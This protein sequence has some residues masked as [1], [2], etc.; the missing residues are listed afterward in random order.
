[1]NNKE[2]VTL[3]KFRKL[4][5]VNDI[6]H[7]KR[8]IENIDDKTMLKLKLR[9]WDKINTIE[10]DESVEKTDDSS[11]L[12]N[13]DKITSF[14]DKLN[15]KE[16][17]ELNKIVDEGLCAKC[18][19][20]SIVCPTEDI[21]FSDFP[22]INNKCD[23][24]GHG[25]CLEVCPRINSGSSTIRSIINSKEEFYNTSQFSSDI[26]E[27]GDYI[28][29]NLMDNN[30]IDGAI[31]VGNYKWKPI[32]MIVTDSESITDISK[33]QYAISTLDAI[34]E[35]GE[36]GLK[37]IAI[38]GLPC[39]IA[40]LRNIQYFKQ[41]TGHEVEASSDGKIAKI[42]KIEYL[43]GIFCKS[44][45]EHDDMLEIL[46]EKSI[47]INNVTK[48][49]IKENK[50]LVYEENLI[51]SISYDEINPSS[52]CLMCND[53]DA[54]LADISIGNCES[55]DNISIV[56]RTGKG[57]EILE[58]L[59]VQEGLDFEV[60][61]RQKENKNT[62]FT[63]EINRRSRE[64]EYNSYY[65][66]WKYPGCTEGRN[67]LVNIL[68][69]TPLAGIY[70]LDTIIELTDIAKKYDV[71]LNISNRKNFHLENIHPK[72]IDDIYSE[73]YKVTDL[74]NSPPSSNLIACVG[75]HSCKMSLINTRDLELE[76]H[77]L[78]TSKGISSKFKVGIGGCAYKCIHY[79][80]L[81]F[82]IHPVKY[83]KIND[84]CLGCGRCPEICTQQGVYIEDNKAVINEENCIGC[85]KCFNFCPNDAKDIK[86]EGY[87]LYIGG[88]A[89]RKLAEASTIEVYNE[90][91][92]LKILENVLDLT[93][94]YAS[95]PTEKVAS[96]MERI[97]K[98]EF[99]KQVKTL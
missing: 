22:Y 83:P 26:T 24:K 78:L 6:I 30:K 15:E 11:P 13:F 97:G 63:E 59:D 8:K 33:E 96:I 77:K 74:F 90:D 76:C 29:K 34:T 54:E 43:I 94:E 88:R 98:D 38:I 32:S 71:N 21:I 10:S 57:R 27:A 84:E 49:E 89:V 40:G 52:G 25:M 18:G 60:F 28:L 58:Y 55:D 3:A 50:V 51:H 19:S 9:V 69:P 81:D 37:K 5:D 66:I 41:N 73:L 95:Y 1:M 80:V 65:Y 44:K 45:Y 42:P 85:S 48:F 61:N 16:E 68:L 75:S 70:N 2:W 31:F 4:R 20:C 14:I 67:G 47:D 46:K 12:P 35:A 86:F 82:A 91:E 99:I 36:M 17:W 87:R 64:G 7:K 92:A 62:R 79:T 23:R 39:Q 72:D 53:Y 56:V 93:K